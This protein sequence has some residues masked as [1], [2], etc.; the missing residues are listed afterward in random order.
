MSAAEPA[1]PSGGT[2]HMIA[3]RFRVIAKVGL[4]GTAVVFRCVDERTGRFAAVKVL[5][6]QGP[7]IPEAVRRFEREARLAASLSHRHIVRVL[8][9]GYCS[10]PPMPSRPPWAADDGQPVP[11]VAMEY[12]FGPNLKEVVRKHGPLPLTWVWV[13][14]E[15]LCSALNAAHALN[16]IHRDVKPQNVMLVDSSL[17]LLAKLTDFGIARQV[18][19]DYTTLTVTGQ[20]LGTPDYLSPEQVMGEPGDPSSDLYSLGI[21]LYELLTGRLPFEAESPLAAASR[22]MVADAPPPSRY[23]TDIPSDVED[24]IMLTL[25]RDPGARPTSAAE[26]RDMLRWS[27]RQSPQVPEGPT[28]GWLVRKGEPG[29][30]PSATSGPLATGDALAAEP[31]APPDDPSQMTQPSE[32]PQRKASAGGEAEAAGPAEPEPQG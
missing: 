4:G 5:R 24:V 16:V 30:G 31:A 26:L 22:R 15:Q 23:R 27:R 13:L 6:T 8:D 25:Q 3:D 2:V 14:G 19:G 10:A 12:V 17:E 7:Q 20:V 11:Y 21:V 32:P 28:G 9:S 29:R 18:G 1:T